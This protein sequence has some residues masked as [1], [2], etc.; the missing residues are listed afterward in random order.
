LPRFLSS[1]RLLVVLAL[2]LAFGLAAGCSTLGYYAQSIS[3]HLSM[4]SSARPVEDVLADPTTAPAVRERLMRIREMRAFASRELG[5]PDN[6]SY[7][8][9]ADI[10]RPFV[11]WNVFAARE[12]SMELKQ[13]C[14]PVVGCAGYRGYFDRT[15]A[16]SMAADLRADNY[17]VAVVGVPAY[18]TLGWLPDPLLNTFIGGTEGQVA[19]LVFHELAHQ[20][21][22][23]G[24]DTIFNESFATAVER[25]GVRRWLD[26]NGDLA[27][28]TAYTDFAQRRQQFI[29][30]LLRYRDRLE[31]LYV[32]ADDDESKRAGKRALFAALRADYA[33][34]RA[35]WGGFAGYD[36]FFAQDLNNANLASIGAYNALV[37]AFDAL[38]AREGGDLPRFYEAVR[39]L[40]ALPKGERDAAL[41]GLVV[42]R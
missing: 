3:G 30:L 40:A 22:F 37:P 42:T 13:W 38:L 4:L 33:E 12:L 6:A 17:E 27:T 34:L 2:L 28:R 32:G 29:D 19:A 14:Y 9:Y 31:A 20:V 41:R 16:E 15:N 25:E 5:L 7:R 21:V 11:V 1:R 36:R 24:G 39:K 35:S 10:K 18:S 26:A 23:V 8:S